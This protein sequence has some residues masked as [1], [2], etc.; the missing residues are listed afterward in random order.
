MEEK[1]NCSSNCIMDNT[2]D[3]MIAFQHSDALISTYSSLI[4]E[5][6]VTGKPVMIFQ[7]QQPADIK[8]RHIID[9]IP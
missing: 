2:D 8:E 6:M 3:Y 4:N 7:K 9:G 1:I 5:Y